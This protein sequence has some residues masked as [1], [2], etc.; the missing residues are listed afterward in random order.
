[1]AEERKKHPI[2]EMAGAKKHPIQEMN[3]EMNKRDNRT[4]IKGDFRMNREE[5]DGMRRVNETAQ[6]FHPYKKK[7]P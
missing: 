1:M 4:P 5:K 6:K 7:G 2:S 3:I